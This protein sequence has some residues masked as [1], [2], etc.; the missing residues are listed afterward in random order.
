M[1]RTTLA[2][3]AALTLAAAPAYAQTAK[4]GA[5]TPSVAASEPTPGSDAW[6]RMRGESYSAAPDSEQ[7]PAEVNATI[8]LNA[9]IA[10]ANAAAEAAEQ[11]AQAAFEAQNQAWRNEVSRSNTAQAQWEADVAA[12]AAARAQWERNRAA[13]E[14][15]LAAC[16]ASGRTCITQPAVK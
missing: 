12:A 15:E 2:C 16:R 3:L 8:K 1:I 14:A 6:L 11:R 13:Y 7:D 4:P 9:D 5:T 10:A